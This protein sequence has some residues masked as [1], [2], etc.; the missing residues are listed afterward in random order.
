MEKGIWQEIEELNQE[1]ITLGISQTVD[2]EKYYLYSLITH[3]TAIEGS[4]LTEME[5][6]LLFDEGVTAKGKPLIHHLMNEDLKQAYEFAMEEAERDAVI[7]PKLLQD[8][9]AMLM[10]TTGGVHSTMAGSF[11]SSKGE[12]RLCGV[13][14][15]RWSFLYELFESLCEG[16]WVLPDC[17]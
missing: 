10:R 4:T 6:Q 2:Y 15:Y 13:G 7:T 9:N 3:S 12:Y 11:D 17:K 8:L 14:W 1:F 16:R 5:I